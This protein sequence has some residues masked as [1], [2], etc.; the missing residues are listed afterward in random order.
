[1]SKELTEQWRNET[2]ERDF[3]YIVS[4]SNDMYFCALI[5]YKTE[6]HWV[7]EV[8][9]KVPTYEQFV[10]LTEKVDSLESRLK[11]AEEA[12]KDFCDDCTL[13]KCWGCDEDCVGWK[14]LHYFERYGKR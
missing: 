9:A 2:L 4:R 14:A 5:D 11:D 13:P 8:L 10:E 7:K 3:Y 12:L 1:M 6:K